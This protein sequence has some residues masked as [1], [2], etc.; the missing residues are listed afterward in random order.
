MN[1]P[2]STLFGGLLMAATAACSIV[3][4]D[5]ADKPEFKGM[6]LYSWQT[7]GK[8][9]HFSLLI[10]TN[11]LKTDEEIKK[12]E[13]TITGMKELKERLAKLAK[14]ESVFWKNLAAEPIPEEMAEDLKAFCDGIKVKLERP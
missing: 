5:R 4:S 6:E 7:D 13:Q 3:F 1:R 11:R 2:Y 9:W 10:G 12:P 14:G 8:D